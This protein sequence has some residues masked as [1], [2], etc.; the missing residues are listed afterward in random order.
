[1]GYL[2][3]AIHDSEPDS[4]IA[5]VAKSVMVASEFLDT[6]PYELPLAVQERLSVHL[7]MGREQL[8]DGLQQLYYKAPWQCNG[9]LAEKAK[10]CRQKNDLP[11]LAFT[12]LNRA[13]LFTDVINKPEPALA[14]ID[15]AIMIWTEIGD[16]EQLA[17]SIKAR[18]L[19]FCAMQKYSKAETE[20]KSALKIFSRNNAQY[21]V[22]SCQLDLVKVYALSGEP[23]SMKQYDQLCRTVLESSD[24]MRLFVL[25]TNRLAAFQTANQYSIRD[26]AKQNHD[27]LSKSNLHPVQVIDFYKRAIKAFEF[28]GESVLLKT[29]RFEYEQVKRVL[30]NEGYYPGIFEN[31]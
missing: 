24:T 1:M 31:K 27:L 17:N 2:I 16:N 6:I 14:L 21:G 8:F 26:F 18:G 13:F 12:Y 10:L 23:D 7:P 22:I 20:I 19:V 9:F 5:H 11:Q 15:S 4:V 3:L 30:L 29:Y 25:N 28:F